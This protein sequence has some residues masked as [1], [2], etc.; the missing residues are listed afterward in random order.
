MCG[1]G[2]SVRGQQGLGGRKPVQCESG[3]GVAEARDRTEHPEDVCE[4]G[5]LVV[6]LAITKALHLRTL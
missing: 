1:S 3:I 2:G 4:K 5:L 6:S